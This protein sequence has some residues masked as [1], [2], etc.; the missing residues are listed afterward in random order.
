M[1]RLILLL[2]FVLTACSSKS[3]V[4]A[5]TAFLAQHWAA[6][7]AAQGIPP[8]HFSPIEASLASETCGQCHQAQF[9][10]WQS[11]LHRH[12][13]GAGIQW[14]FALLGQEESNK[15]LRCHAPLAEQKAV[16]AQRL[17]WPNAPGTA[18]PGYVPADFDQ[19]GLT[20]AGCH[21]RKHQRFGPPAKTPLV[22]GTPHNGFTVSAAFEDSRFCMHCHQFPQD[23][24]RLAGKLREDTYAQWRASPYAD[25]QTCQNCHMLDRQHLWR[26]IHDPEMF[27]KGLKVDVVLRSLGAGRYRVEVTA[28]NVGAG[29]HLP[30]YMVPKIY[31]TTEWVGDS[32]GRKPIGQDVIGWM[33][34]VD[35]K[36]EVFDTRI[37]AGES[38][39][40]VHEFAVDEGADWRVETRVDVAPREQYERMFKH[41]LNVTTM[42]MEAAQTLRQAIQEAM[43]TRYT[44]MTIRAKP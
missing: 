17:N 41:N 4:D 43:A 12:T 31:L 2:G 40:F 22:A 27:R 16:L 1:W 9:Q 23:G 33:A 14:Q 35:I 42:S 13:M 24:N 30:T 44:A 21:V 8:A 36:H 37:P 26:G 11:A 25:K 34:D 28:W 18:P 32:G 10:Q 19:A 38:R 20:C 29:H 5:N 3:E 15:C 6:P 39:T 7:V